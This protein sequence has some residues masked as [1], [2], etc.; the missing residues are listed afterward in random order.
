MAK[1]ENVYGLHAIRHILKRSPERVLALTVLRRRNDAPLRGILELAH[2]FGV[3]VVMA[4]RKTLD[5]LTDGSVHQGVV[6]TV[7][8]A[9]P[10][11]E[12]DLEAILDDP[13]APPFLLILDGI[14]DP[15]NLGA[16][17]RTADACGV[18]AVIVPKKGA[19]GLTPAVRKVASGAA[20]AVPFI[21]VT[22]LARTIETI[23]KHGVTTVALTSD[24][25]SS[26]HSADLTGS[27]AVVIGSEGKGLGRLIVETCDIVVSLPMVGSVESLNVSVTAAVSLYE[28]LRQRGLQ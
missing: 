24:A 10:L 14:Q 18:D 23:K 26:I 25:G 1:P 13:A 12:A 17:L 7:R 28:I 16:C 21:T 4:E 22:N 3:A 27:I 19:V 8:P 15:H 5:R 2:K 6:A 9:R 11:G 20:E